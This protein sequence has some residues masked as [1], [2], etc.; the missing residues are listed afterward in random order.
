MKKKIL[1]TLTVAL[2]FALLSGC[3]R[4]ETSSTADKAASS[5][6]ALSNDEILPTIEGADVTQETQKEVK[7]K[8][9]TVDELAAK[10]LQAVCEKDAETFDALAASCT[11]KYNGYTVQYY[12]ALYNDWCKAAEKVG[13]DLKNLTISASDWKVYRLD[14]PLVDYI[15][16]EMY[17]PPLSDSFGF[18]IG[19]DEFDYNTGTYSLKYI[20][21]NG[22]RTENVLKTFDECVNTGE[23]ITNV[24]AAVYSVDIEKYL[25]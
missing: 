8:T 9:E 15:W 7:T 1:T 4:S 2:S 5:S 21:S 16:V 25:N 11:G 6:S 14:F 23:M 13:I 17:Y 20:H 22:G 19:I 10:V 3:G 12:S 24:G 18:A